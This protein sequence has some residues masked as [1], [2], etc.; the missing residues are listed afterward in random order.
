VNARSARRWGLA[1][2]ATA[3][4]GAG[5]AAFGS[6]ATLT[7]TPRNHSAYRTCV[8]TAYPTTSTVSYDAWVDEN[9]PNTN[10][11]GKTTVQLESRSGRNRRAYLRFDLTKCIPTVA[12]GAT[13]ETA[14]LRLNLATAPTANRTYNIY[15]VTGPCPEGATTCWTQNGLVWTNQPTVA[16]TATS[17]LALTSSSPIN[18]YY[19]FD[20]TADAAAM[21]AGTVSNYGWQIADAA[22]GA[23]TAVTAAF[24]AKNAT[25]NAAG[26]P[27]LVLVYSP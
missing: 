18:R 10:N 24:K 27:Q 17:A 13:V 23:A 15:R 19:A 7:V 16:A 21:V 8:L 26:A 4:A 12:A 20:V 14:T 11:G 6:A 3:L 25:S 22:E 9:A 2:G 5:W 1:A